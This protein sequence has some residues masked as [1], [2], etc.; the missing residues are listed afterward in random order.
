MNNANEELALEALDQVSGGGGGLDTMGD[1]SQIMQMRLQK[2][3]DA[4]TKCFEMLSNVMHKMGNTSS[5][6]A[7]NM[8]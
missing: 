6:I 2:Y 7:Q 4:Y 3:L 8:K 1:M 5:Q